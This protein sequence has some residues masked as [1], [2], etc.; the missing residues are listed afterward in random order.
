MGKYTSMLL[1][2]FS[3]RL[4]AARLPSPHRSPLPAKAS[5]S[6]FLGWYLTFCVRYRPFP[7]PALPLPYYPSPHYC[8]SLTTLLVLLRQ[9][10]ATP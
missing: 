8:F 7:H 9:I 4:Y 3:A 6:V 10:T 2:S 5:L 1:V